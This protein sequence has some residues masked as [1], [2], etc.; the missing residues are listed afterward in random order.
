MRLSCQ[1][2]L[3]ATFTALLPLCPLAFQGWNSGTSLAGNAL[4]FSQNS[5]ESVLAQPNAT[6]GVQITG[7]DISKDWPGEV[8]DGWELGI[9]VTKSLTSAQL[10]SSSDQI[11]G[12]DQQLFTGTS[13]YL[14]AP[15]NVINAVRTAQIATN[16][17]ASTTWMICVF[18]ITDAPSGEVDR[19]D[20]NGT[21]KAYSSQCVTDLQAAYVERF[22]QEQDCFGAAP[23]MPQ[24]CGGLLDP[25]NFTTQPFSIPYLNGTEIYATASEP[26]RSR[27][28]LDA[29]YDSAVGQVWP[30]LIVWGW[31]KQIAD[32]RR[33]PSVQLVI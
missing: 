15:P 4:E 12:E 7:F 9:N 22:A 24:S 23:M 25:A 33:V 11:S 31:I 26:L 14:K 13:I 5:W 20:N 32:A 10:L 27:A 3:A 21:C 29:A 6:G 16:A 1:F 18:F 19:S 2:P 28:D 17:D 8:V 30:V